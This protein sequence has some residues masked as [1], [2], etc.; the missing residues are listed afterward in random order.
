MLKKRHD[1]LDIRLYARIERGFFLADNEW[2]CYRRNYFQLSG[3]FTL[4]GIGVIYEGQE[5]P[6]LVQ[7]GEGGGLH[8]IRSFRLGVT[9]RIANSEKDVPLIQHTPKRDKGPQTTPQPKPIRPGGNLTMASV[10]GASSQLTVTFERLQF[11]SATA[12]NGKRRAAQQYYVLVMEL[13]AELE[14]SG[15]LITVATT[16]SA[17]LVVR[18]RSP[19]HYAEAD[20]AGQQ[21]QQAGA[22][23][24]VIVQEGAR[25]MSSNGTLPRPPSHHYHP[26]RPPIFY[27]PEYSSYEYPS[28]GYPPA[29]AFVHGQPFPF[30]QHHERSNSMS[31]P[32]SSCTDAYNNGGPQRYPVQDQWNRMRMP[33]SASTN[34]TDSASYPYTVRSPTTYYDGRTALPM[35]PR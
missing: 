35:Q 29:S 4:Q 15:E 1:R 11:K 5:L 17:N 14:G 13:F 6:C 24:V 20:A 19:G 2:T 22:G 7:H 33:S 16:E 12:N 34:S 9:A 30:P 18:G 23:G 31:S 27:G 28:L 25:Y 10:G 21:Q 26:D 32:L 8:P 3:A